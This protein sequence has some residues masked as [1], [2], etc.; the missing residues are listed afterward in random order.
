MARKQTVDPLL[1]GKQICFAVAGSFRHD[2][3]RL[4]P[5]CWRRWARNRRAQKNAKAATDPETDRPNLVSHLMRAKRKDAEQQ[6]G[7]HVNA[8]EHNPGH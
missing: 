6:R 3:S 8:T 1:L 7:H 5:P 4:R 2:S